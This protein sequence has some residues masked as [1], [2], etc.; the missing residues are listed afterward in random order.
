MVRGL[1]YHKQSCRFGGLSTKTSKWLLKIAR[2][3]LVTITVSHKRDKPRIRLGSQLVREWNGK[4]YTVHVTDK[5]YVM[6]GVTYGSLS[7]AAKARSLTDF[8]KLVDVFDAHDVSFVSVTQAFNTTTSMGR[9]TLNVLLSFAQFER[10]VTAERIRDK[11]AASKAKG[12]WMGGTCPIGYRH[13]DRKL[14][15]RE[16]EAAIVRT[17]FQLYLDHRNVTKV[18]AEADK[19]GFLSRQRTQR[20]GKSAGGK[21]LSRGLIYRILQNPYLYRKK[22]LSGSA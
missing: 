2:T 9:L 7:S 8:A 16:D 3:G 19:L 17:L 12:I 20:C 6:S 1:A 11:F 22:T 5:G 15:I 10:E 21:P 18:K 4:S 13:K 14:Y